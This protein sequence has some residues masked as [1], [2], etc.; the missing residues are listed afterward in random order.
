MFTQT[1]SQSQDLN[2]NTWAG[3]AAWQGGGWPTSPL[4]RASLFIS[5][6]TRGG[7]QTDPTRFWS[8][9]GKEIRVWNLKLFKGSTVLCGWV[10]TLTARKT[11]V[12]P[13]CSGLTA[14]ALIPLV[15]A[16]SHSEVVQ[17]HCPLFRVLWFYVCR[18]RTTRYLMWKVLF[19][20]LVCGGREG[21]WSRFF[22]VNFWCSVWSLLLSRV[23]STVLGLW[24]EPSPECRIA[25]LPYTVSSQNAT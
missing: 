8:N 7:K 18:L 22:R 17:G 2:S 14:S 23:R 21:W 10:L 15:W 11:C 19:L 4:M 6:Q 9:P 3:G 24:A 1:I 12:C 5:S 13:S 25:E 16:L 20:R